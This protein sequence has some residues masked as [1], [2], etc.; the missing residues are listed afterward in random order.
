MMERPI[1]NGGK[2]MRTEEACSY[3]RISPASRSQVHRAT[4]ICNAQGSLW[5][6]LLV[7]P[8]VAKKSCARVNNFEDSL[9]P[10]DGD[11]ECGDCCVGLFEKKNTREKK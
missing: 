10:R 11:G 2:L 6:C 7:I 1:L 9:L 3:L 5:T 8:G 4:S